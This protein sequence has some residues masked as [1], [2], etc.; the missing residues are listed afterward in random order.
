M[1]GSHASIPETISR[2]MLA[3][4]TD[5]AAH[6]V[7]DTTYEYTS[8]DEEVI[9]DAIGVVSILFICMQLVLLW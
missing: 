4:T 9:N 8:H 1:K 6:G 3:W 5:D 2:C 7:N